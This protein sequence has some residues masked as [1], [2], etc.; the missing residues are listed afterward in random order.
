MKNQGAG[1]GEREITRESPG[2]QAFSRTPQKEEEGRSA[3]AVHKSGSKE[4]PLEERITRSK[5]SAVFKNLSSQGGGS[6]MNCGLMRKGIVID[7]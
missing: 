5:K 4:R 3:A 7:V 6:R 1:R 2:L